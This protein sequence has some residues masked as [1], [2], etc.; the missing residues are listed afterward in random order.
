MM[1]PAESSALRRSPRLGAAYI[2]ICIFGIVFL[3]IGAA[4]NLRW[5]MTAGG[6][7]TFVGLGLL[8][9]LTFRSRPE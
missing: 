1:W 3:V 2:T 5:S 7:L 8:L 4:T 6:A 9:V